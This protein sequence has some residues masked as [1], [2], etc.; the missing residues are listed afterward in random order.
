MSDIF[1]LLTTGT[2]FNKKK[3]AESIQLFEKAARFHQ[4]NVPDIS[5]ELSIFLPEDARE[6]EI[7]G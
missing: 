6:D 3:N 5:K 2:N 1:S 4:D 7:N